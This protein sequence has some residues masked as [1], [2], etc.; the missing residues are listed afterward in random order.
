MRMVNVYPARSGIV[1][2]CSGLD[3]RK[4]SPG[5]LNDLMRKREPADSEE[6]DFRRRNMHSPALMNRHSIQSIINSWMLTGMSPSGD[7]HYR[8]HTSHMHCHLDAKKVVPQT[9]DM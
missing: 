5:C 8:K 6:L 1:R 3:E 2:W 7:L 4:E 9:T